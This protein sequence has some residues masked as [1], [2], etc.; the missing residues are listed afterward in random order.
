MCGP[1]VLASWH[2]VCTVGQLGTALDTALDELESMQRQEGA[3][4]VVDLRERIGRL[5]ELM[6]RIDRLASQY[7]DDIQQRLRDKVEALLRPGG[8]NE[9][10]LATEI[11]LIAERSDITE[12]VVRFRSHT[13]QFVEA[14]DSGGEIGR[15]LNF[16][17]QEMHREVNTM[18]SKSSHQDLIH[19]AVDAKEEVERLREQI[20][21]LA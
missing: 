11:V 20:Q 8:L 16:L 1:V 17:L 12:E 2:F 7:R 9:D 15:R 10:R 5:R 6:D 14:L 18:S 3:T 13:E 19:T 4:L 21:N